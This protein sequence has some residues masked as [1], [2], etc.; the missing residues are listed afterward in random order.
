MGASPLHTVPNCGLDNDNIYTV[1]TMR[2]KGDPKGDMVSGYP[3]L[4]GKNERDSLLVHDP[5]VFGSTRR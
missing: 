1:S 2:E 4:S 3:W 5:P